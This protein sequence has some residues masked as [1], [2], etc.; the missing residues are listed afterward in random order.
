MRFYEARI[1]ILSP[2]IIP[3]RRVERGYKGQLNYIPST[4]LRG[5]ILTSLYTHGYISL[6]EAKSI[7]GSYEL[8][9]SNAYLID[10]G[11]KSY[12]SHPFMYKCKVP[13]KNEKGETVI[14]S[15]I[16]IS[17][18]DVVG[19]L[20]DGRD[21]K[22]KFECSMGHVAIEYP[23]PRPVRK[24]DKDGEAFREVDVKVQSMISVGISKR[25]A[26]SQAGMLYEYDAMIEGQEFWC[27]IGISK[28]SIYERI[29]G[30]LEIKI[31]RGVSRGFGHSIIEEV[32]EISLDKM[33]GDLKS[34]GV[35]VE[36]RNIVFYALSPL[37]E[38]DGLKSY[39]PYP[40]KLNLDSLME[41]CEI[42]GKA[43]VLEIKKVYGKSRTLH[44]GWDMHG[45]IRRPI[46]EHVASEGCIAVGS[47]TG[48]GN[49]PQSLAILSL[50]GY[51]IKISENYM[52][53]GVNMLTPIQIHP[54][55]WGEKT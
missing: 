54:F 1:K 25:R 14:E 49:I 11:F 26:T 34:S 10:D 45:N 5:A 2:T 40:S 6:E 44:C 13:H 52:L 46:F 17:E 42:G 43:G 39:K 55:L 23:H 47:I 33:M 16:F 32:R 29:K 7:G 22:F 20:K 37:L 15:K 19:A 48:G 41:I 53:T 18:Y 12:P 51:P 8:L 50:I 27:Y 35:A 3:G 31:G 4:T 36:G 9:V 28:D 30:G 38:T 21:P 24:S